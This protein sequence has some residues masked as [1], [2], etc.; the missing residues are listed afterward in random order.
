[1]NVTYDNNLVFKILRNASDV[2]EKKSIQ[3]FFLYFSILW[4]EILMRRITCL[5]Q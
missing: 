4:T 2:P 5:L 3:Y 1:M